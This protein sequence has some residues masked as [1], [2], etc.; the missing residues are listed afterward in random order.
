M[1]KRARWILL[2]VA[3]LT[4]V[5]FGWVKLRRGHEPVARWP[6]PDGTELRLEQVTYGTHHVMP[7]AGKIADWY[8]D[9]TMRFRLWRLPW[10]TGE[11]T[12]DTDSPCP[13]L[14]FTRR[15]PA[16]GK[17]DSV[18]I[19][20]VEVVREPYF[21]SRLYGGSGDHP[22]RPNIRYAVLCYDR[23]KPTF[24]V[25]AVVADK[26]FEFDVKN[27]V[28]GAVFP[29]WT[30]EPLPQTKKTGDF[31]VILRGFDVTQ[32]FNGEPV[33]DVLADV[34]KDGKEADDI[35]AFLDYADATGNAY[36]SFHLWGMPP[37]AEPAWKVRVSIRPKDDANNELG[38]VE[39]IVAPPK[40][41]AEGK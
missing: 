14:W 28:A 31:E 9:M 6:L 22:P 12:E 15:D 21:R 41:P 40:L 39:F 2:G 24:R 26:T 37:L 35:F 23:R 13:V 34:L 25:R 20:S 33:L 11:Y 30:P 7:G 3:V 29:E 27:P 36:D 32:D 19:D 4:V 16:K 18:Q 5:G 10:L 17:F 8:D 38:T 1:G